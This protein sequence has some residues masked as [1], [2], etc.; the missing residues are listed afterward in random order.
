MTEKKER[1]KKAEPKSESETKTPSKDEKK[2]KEASPKKAEAKETSDKKD[3]KSVVEQGTK[4]IKKVSK[5]KKLVLSL[6][7]AVGV[8]TSILMLDV[9]IAWGRFELD[10]S[11]S[12]V[13]KALN[14]PDTL[15]IIYRPDCG[16]CRQVL[17]DLF[18]RHALSKGREYVLDARKLTP[19]QKRELGELSTPTFAYKGEGVQT[20]DNDEIEGIW[21]KSHH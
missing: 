13:E 11:Q 12:T 21:Q 19:E 8:I 5:K 16:R 17:P 20:T 14:D 1:D 18:M 6:A 7:I 15:T 10:K 9:I 4:P 2:T 3:E